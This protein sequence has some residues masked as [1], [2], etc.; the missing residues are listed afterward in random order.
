MLIQCI[1][2]IGTTL[3]TTEK[4]Y[5]T[6]EDMQK[7]GYSNRILSSHRDIHKQDSL[8]IRHFVM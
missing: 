6:F 8:L 1:P 7:D 3:K 4:S 5:A 2:Y